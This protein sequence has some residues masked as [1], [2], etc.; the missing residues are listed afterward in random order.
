ML[1]FF[2]SQILTETVR[3]L[4]GDAR[5]NLQKV[6][7]GQEEKEGLPLFG[8]DVLTGSAVIAKAAV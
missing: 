5:P 4:F 7:E 8:K 3:S 1:Q 2:A 6:A